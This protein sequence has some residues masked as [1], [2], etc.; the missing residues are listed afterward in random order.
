MIRLFA[1]IDVQIK[2]GC[3]Y[4]VLDADSKYI[5]S[6]WITSDDV[7]RFFEIFSEL[8]RNEYSTIAIG[9]DAP[10]MSLKNLRQRYYVRGKD[11]W[12][13]KE[14][15]SIGRECEVIINSHRL[16]NCQW[17]NTCQNSP[18]WMKLGYKIFNSLQEFKYLHEV[19]PSASYKMLENEKLKYELSLENFRSGPKDM[20][21]ASVAAITVK[22]FH[23]GRGCEVGN[24]DGLG[25]IILPRK[26]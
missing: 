12:I 14:K 10:R 18:K 7:H 2:R 5:A 4:Y 1:G 3:C 20:L 21:D 8:S 17:T 25:T 26:L 19:F 22:E 9:V 15:K 11:E 23:E 24:G 13:I 6:G 16:A